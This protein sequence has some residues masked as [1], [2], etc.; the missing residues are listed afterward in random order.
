MKRLVKMN[1]TYVFVVLA[2]LCLL[3]Q[4]RSGQF[5]RVYNLIDLLVAL[6]VPAMFALN[7]HVV[8]AS[9]GIDVSFPC[10]ASFCMY[11]VTRILQMIEY[12][13]SVVLAFVMAAVIGAIMGALNGWLIASFRL[14]PLIVTL[15]TQSLFTGVLMGVL[16]AIEISGSKLPSC[17]TS[18]GLQRLYET[19]NPENNIITYIPTS[20]LI[21]VGAVIVTYVILK[22]TMF[23]RSIFAVGNDENAALRAGIPVKR[24]KIAVYCYAGLV[25][26]VAGIV[27]MCITKF[28]HPTNLT[29]IEMEVIA[30]VVLGGTSIAGGK[31][32]ITGAMLGIALI[33]VMSNSLLL[34]G[35]PVQWQ[36][37][38]TGIL[39]IFGT[40]LSAYQA[41]RAGK[42]LMRRTKIQPAEKPAAEGGQTA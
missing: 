20:L 2:L 30:A 40:G 12:Q 31:G 23:G 15:G 1:E 4:A 16:E 11:V 33:T 39:I 42:K 26:G 13:G 36:T 41:M 29:G 28:C 7:T 5:F 32:S 22:H 3:V 37:F 27:R 6:I 19:V 17:I 35:I 25:A 8:I 10:I 21:L 24:I 38:C 34:L 14:P 18:F 9:G